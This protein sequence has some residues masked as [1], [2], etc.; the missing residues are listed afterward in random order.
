[1]KIFMTVCFLLSAA[2]LSALVAEPAR[3]DLRL[4]F[5]DN[6]TRCHGADGT[7]R[8]ALGKRLKG[9]DFTDAGWRKGTTD[10][11]MVETILKGRFFGRAMPS[12]KKRLTSEEAQRMVTEIIRRTSKGEEIAPHKAQPAA[13]KP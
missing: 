4:F 7:A 12:F 6:C 10:A 1:M 11:K 13:A 8:D 5:K 3:K 2:A 9:Q